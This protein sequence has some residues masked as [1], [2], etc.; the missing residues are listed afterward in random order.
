AKWA[1]KRLPT[2]AEWELA[3]RGGEAG[4]IYSWGNELKRNGKWMANIYQGRFP[5]EDMG[6][7]AFKGIAPVAQFPT[8]GYGL[9]DM[10]GNVWE[11]CSDWYRRDAYEGQTSAVARNP[12]GPDSSYDPVEPQEKKRVHRGGSFLCTDQYCTRYMVGSR[13]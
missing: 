4:Q 12:T 7:D 3:A 13:G 9:Y 5:I 2:G 10:A 6:E 1:G 8:N 11:W